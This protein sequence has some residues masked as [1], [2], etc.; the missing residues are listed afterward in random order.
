MYLKGKFRQIESV[1]YKILM[2]LQCL[3]EK[4]LVNR[5]TVSKFINVFS[6]AVSHYTVLLFPVLCK[7][8]LQG[9]DNCKDPHGRILEE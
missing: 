1:F 3:D 7:L 8:N 9:V 6:L 2:H 4:T 5:W